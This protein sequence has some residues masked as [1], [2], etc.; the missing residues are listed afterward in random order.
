MFEFSGARATGEFSIGLGG[1]T[2]RLQDLPSARP[3]R[4]SLSL[5]FGPAC[6]LTTLLLSL[7]LTASVVYLPRANQPAR[8]ISILHNKVRAGKQGT[9]CF[10]SNVTTAAEPTLMPSTPCFL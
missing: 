8:H 7:L 6:L 9:L 3:R 2:V 4:S 1:S 5:F 10:V